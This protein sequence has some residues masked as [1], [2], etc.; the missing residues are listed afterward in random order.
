MHKVIQFK[1]YLAAA[2]SLPMISAGSAVRK[3]LGSMVI[4][5]KFQII[6]KCIER[7]FFWRL[8]VGG[9]GHPGPFLD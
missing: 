8:P 9:H 7:S 6:R 2:W 3:K 5:Q 1:R 4:A